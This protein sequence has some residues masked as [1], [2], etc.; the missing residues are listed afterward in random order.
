MKKEKQHNKTHMTL[1]GLEPRTLRFEVQ[2]TT[3]WASNS[4][5]Y[6]LEIE[7]IWHIHWFTYTAYNF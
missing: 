7:Y 5:G 3:L 1:V 2:Q 4:D 6:N